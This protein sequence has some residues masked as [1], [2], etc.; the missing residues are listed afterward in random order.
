LRRTK[1]LGKRAFSDSLLASHPIY[2]KFRIISA[3]ADALVRL[4]ILSAGFPE[5][6]EL[7]LNPVKVFEEGKGVVVVD[8]RI[9][10]VP[11]FVQSDI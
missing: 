11:S 8:G 2:P 1:S 9:R 7:N 4:S 5:M 6:A 3:H 10:T